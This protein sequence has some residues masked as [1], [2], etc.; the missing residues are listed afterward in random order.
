MTDIRLVTDNNAD[1]NFRLVLIDRD[2]Q[3]YHLLLR[4][5][6]ESQPVIEQCRFRL[7][8]REPNGRNE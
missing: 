1:N 4:Y 5:R 7:V 3:H 8:D 2:R 6:R